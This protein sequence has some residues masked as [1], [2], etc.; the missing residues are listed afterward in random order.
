MKTEH[1]HHEQSGV[2]GGK[3]VVGGMGDQWHDMVDDER[4]PVRTEAAGHYDQQ[5]P[6]HPARSGGEAENDFACAR[7]GEPDD[8]AESDDQQVAKM[9]RPDNQA[10]SSGVLNFT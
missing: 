2:I 4:S 5:H 6:S 8:Q 1:D 9:M 3:A 10:S 7:A